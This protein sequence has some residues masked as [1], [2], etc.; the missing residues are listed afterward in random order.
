MEEEKNV[1]IKFNITFS[2]SEQKTLLQNLNLDSDS[3]SK[4]EDV[5]KKMAEASFNEYKR[6]LTGVFCFQVINFLYSLYLVYKIL[7]S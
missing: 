3:S 5:L 1:E 4:I 7:S 2:E 6:M